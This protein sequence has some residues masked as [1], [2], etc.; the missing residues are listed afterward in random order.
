METV[1]IT[2]RAPIYDNIVHK[3]YDGTITISEFGCPA[4]S[5]GVQIAEY[6]NLTA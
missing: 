5:G 6:A 2:I 3:M 4:A 1:V